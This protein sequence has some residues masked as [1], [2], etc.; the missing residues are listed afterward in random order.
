MRRNRLIGLSLGLYISLATGL[1]TLPVFAD[2]QDDQLAT[3]NKR[4]AILEAQ[5]KVSQLEDKIAQAQVKAAS[6]LAT[7]ASADAATISGS[8]S[9]KATDEATA[10]Y[11]DVT[12]LQKVL[13]D[14][15]DIGVDGTI[16][17]NATDAA[18]LLQSRQGG[19][20]AARAAADELCAALRANKGL[21]QGLKGKPIV[22]ISEQRLEQIV[23]AK[24]RTLRFNELYKA[25][26]EA[27]LYPVSVT[28]G[29]KP[30]LIDELFGDDAK[31]F[32]APV[33]IAGLAQA[34]HIVS[35]V[36]NLAGVARV[37]KAYSL[38]TTAREDLF[39]SRLSTCTGVMDA[40]S[41][42]RRA[43]R[44]R[45]TTSLANYYKK[46]QKMQAFA[47]TVATERRDFDALSK[48]TQK[49]ATNNAIKAREALAARVA[50]LTATD[51]GIA[52]DLALVSMESVIADKPILTYSLAIQDTQIKKDRF[53]L[54]DKLTYQGTAEVV[55]Q[56]TSAEGAILEGDAISITSK[57]YDV[58]STFS[59]KAL[60]N[61]GANH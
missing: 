24:L 41:L 34:Q 5:E 43:D 6:A 51:D 19:I 45:L 27:S 35:A 14:T 3:L 47:A 11:A 53:L 31:T 40:S 2:E 54:N 18:V 29:G 48:A 21:Q 22:P 39:E 25:V 46:L 44:D 36:D 17:F 60:A 49:V 59:V 1:T 55:Y 4:L 32:S 9:K 42:K 20:L 61:G 58:A 33:V 8:K 26:E 12:A 30:V 28:G 56:V 37:N 52:S 23:T 16:S 7:A 50:A 15:K 38:Q 57:A 13:G 10:K